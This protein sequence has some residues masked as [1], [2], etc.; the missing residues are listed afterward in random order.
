MV[1]LFAWA[2][3]LLNVLPLLWMAWSSLLGTGDISQGRVFPADYPN[4]VVFFEK[5]PGNRHLAATLHGQVYLFE[6]GSLRESPWKLD[7]SAVSVNYALSDSILY[8]FSPDEGLMAIDIP[9][10]RVSDAWDF[11]VFEKSFESADFTPF[12]LVPGNMPETD[13]SKLSALLDSLPLTESSKE[14]LADVSGSVF[15]ADSSLLDSLNAILESPQKLAEAIS[16][17]QQKKDWV[18]PAIGRLFKKRSRT[19]KENREL[20]RWCLAERVPSPQ[21]VFRQI[22][23]TPIWVNRVPASDHGVSIANVGKYLCVGIWWEPFP[24]VAVIDK[25]NPESI[26]WVTPQNGLLSSSVQ[27]ILRVSETEALVAHDQGFSLLNLSTASVTANY[28]FGESGLPFYNGRDLRFSV[29]S[30]SSVLFACG[31]EIVFFDFRAGRAVKRLYGDYRL[32]QSDI[33]SIRSVG[34]CIFFGLSQGIVEMNLWDLLNEDSRQN[35]FSVEGTATSL[36]V[37]GK[38][39]LVGMQGGTLA[40]VDL[41][42]SR[43]ESTANLPSGGVYLHWRNYEDL[44]RTVPFGRLFFNSLFI[45]LSTVVI[46]LV[47]GSLSGYGF[48]R[49]SFRSHSLANAGLVWSQVVPNILLLIPAFLI[50][51]ALQT[52]AEFRVLNTRWG[53]ILLYS[54]LFLPMATWILQN[55]FRAV[56]KEIEEAALIDGCTPLSAFWR[57]MVPS[58]FPGI[59]TT[60]IYVFILAWD[61]LMVAWVF[62]MDLSTATIPVGMRLFF[63]Q[64]GSRFD[65]M[66]A[67]ATLSTLPVVVLFFFVQNRVLS[68][69]SGGRSNGQQPGAKKFR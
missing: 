18:N 31:R 64:F 34:E 32:F 15:P 43:I 14:T 20:F 12:R 46:C 33:S 16:I 53:I 50:A 55:F 7:L 29:V 42:S 68:G 1:K 54:A 63:G 5:L 2:F 67:A 36:A 37:D 28:L 49:I 52:Y 27:R 13:F 62:S 48:S 19:P 21:T 23:W 47:L 40:V 10:M 8:A 44:W 3:A 25:G 69:I 9:R 59:L 41:K 61:E 65:L 60:G 56:P 38:S 24:G 57:V 45:C 22:P 4:D 17:W 58:A 11:D 35:F 6:G 51:T 26:R 30:R 66:M 39:L